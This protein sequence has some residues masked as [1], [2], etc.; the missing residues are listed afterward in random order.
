M[1]R[2]QAETKYKVHTVSRVYARINEYL[3][4]DAAKAVADF[5]V[6][7]GN[8]DAYELI[9]IIGSG[10]YSLVFLARYQTGYCAIKVLRNIAPVKIKRELFILDRLAGNSGV[11][12][13][14]DVNRDDVTDCVSIV[15]EFIRTDVPKTLYPSLSIDDIRYY[16]FLLLGTLDQCHQRGIMHRD[17]KPGNV[18]IDHRAGILKIIDWGLSEFYYPLTPYSVR[19]ATMRY[20][21]PELLL[22]YRFYDY[23]I[24]IWGAGLVLA[25]MLTE[26]P[27]IDGETQEEVMGNIAALCGEKEI[28]DFCEKYGIERSPEY[29]THIRGK[30][31]NWDVVEKKTRKGLDG[32]CAWDLIRKMLIIDHEDRITAREA[33]MHEF[34]APIFDRQ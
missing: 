10:K 34:F 33:L 23:G 30:T 11:V 7:F 29:Q 24:D 26:I 20:K 14:L 22:G 12:K 13:V 6:K 17:I 1:T 27:F 32:K 3:L 9:G 18:C 25:E 16:T 28:L 2:A 19:V 15:T 21:A 8:M 4:P 31:S 5:R